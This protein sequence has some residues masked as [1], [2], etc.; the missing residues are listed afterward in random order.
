MTER[1]E[2]AIGIFIAYFIAFAVPTGIIGRVFG[3]HQEILRKVYHIFGTASMILLLYVFPGWQSALA[4]FLGLFA[5][6]Y[7]VIVIF[8]DAPFLKRIRRDPARGDTKLRNQVLLVAATFSFLI[9]TFWALGGEENKH[10]ILFGVMT[11]C[12]GD[13]F[14]AVVGRLYGRRNFKHPVFDQRKTH[15]GFKAFVVSATFVN[16]VILVMFYSFP[17]ALTLLIAL[18]IGTAGALIELMSKKGLDNV[19]IP[20]GVSGIAYG[21]INGILLVF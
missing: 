6:A 12:L 8:R 16:T 13:A 7:G 2:V 21:V 3:I 5:L 11:W 14:A 17:L 15:R 10:F 1:V 4:S 9:L 19:L 18:F 20:I